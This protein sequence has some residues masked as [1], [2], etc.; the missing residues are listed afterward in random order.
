MRRVLASL[1]LTVLIGGPVAMSVCEASCLDHGHGHVD[2]AADPTAPEPASPHG[3]HQ[4]SMAEERSSRESAVSS[5]IATGS[6]TT[7]ATVD[8]CL[9]RT[10]VEPVNIPSA[11]SPATT[12]VHVA[13]ATCVCA[14]KAIAAATPAL[15]HALDPPVD[16]VAQHLSAILRI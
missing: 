2:L 9:E 13:A 14:G 8:C 12:L 3:H 6:P 7:L 4:G 10:R 16:S 1:L 11:K 5:P 15:A